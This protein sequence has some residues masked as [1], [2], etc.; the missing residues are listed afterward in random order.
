MKGG[1]MATD[2]KE[3][4]RVTAS[5]VTTYVTRVTPGLDVDAP[6]PVDGGNKIPPTSSYPGS[7]S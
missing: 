4:C 6:S 2:G 5:G 3:S 1:S 7:A